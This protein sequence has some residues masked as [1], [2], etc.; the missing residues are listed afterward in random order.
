MLK[1]NPKRKTKPNHDRTPSSRANTKTKDNPKQEGDLEVVLC[2][3][4]VQAGDPVVVVVPFRQRVQACGPEVVPCGQSGQV[5]DP[6]AISSSLK[7]EEDPDTAAAECWGNEREAVA[8]E[9]LLLHAGRK[10]KSGTYANPRPPETALMEA[11]F[12]YGLER[13]RGPHRTP[14]CIYIQVGRATPPHRSHLSRTCLCHSSASP[15]KALSH[16]YGG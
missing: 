4:R 5:S 16:S 1:N 2:G 9:S 7:R 11:D 3:Q 12:P 15:A 10:V 6:E 14:S 8:W 13:R